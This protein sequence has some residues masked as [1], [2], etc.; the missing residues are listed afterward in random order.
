MADTTNETRKLP[1]WG[2]LLIGLVGTSAIIKYTPVLELLTMFFYIVMVPFML[3]A[4]V[5]ILSQGLIEGALNGFSQSMEAIKERA[6]NKVAA[7]S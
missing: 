7:A 6:A 2:K 5:G 3:L 4:S 1:W